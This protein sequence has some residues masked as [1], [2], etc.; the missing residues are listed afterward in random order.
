[1]LMD[2]KLIDIFWTH[3]VHTIVH[4]QKLIL[5]TTMKKLATSYGNEDQKM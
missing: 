3:A 1:M 4:I 5:K 2:S